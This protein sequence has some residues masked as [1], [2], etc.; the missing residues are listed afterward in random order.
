[1]KDFVARWKGH[2]RI[3]P[4]A[5]PH[6]PYTCSKETLLAARDFALAEGI[7]LLIHVA[8][9][10]QGARR[11]PPRL[12]AEPVRCGS[13]RSASSIPARTAG[14][15]RSSRRTA[16]GWTTQDVAHRSRSTA[17]ALSHNP[18]SNMKLASGIAD[19][20]AWQKAGLAWGLGTDGVAG[21]NNDLSMFEAMDFA[22]KLAKVST[23]DPTVLPA[24]GPRRRGD[25]RRREG[26]RARRRRSAR[27]RPG[28]QADFIAVD[29][30]ERARRAVRRR[31]TRRSSTR[32][33]RRDVT[34]VWVDGRR[35]LGRRGVRRRSTSEAILDEGGRVARKVDAS[36]APAGGRRERT[37]TRE[38]VYEILRAKRDGKEL[39]QGGD[40]V[41]RRRASSRARSPTT[42]R[43]RS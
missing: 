42:R 27:S 14:A 20:V 31:R 25:A 41:P 1:M 6:A 9:T 30:R 4:A 15:S 3:V 36:L 43:R 23:M 5:A 37:S 10:Q 16:S 39:P 22:G 12:A 35:L 18:E 7:P 32:S 24:R 21:S 34:D 28:K 29:V 11:R 2:P 8:E 17:S 19:V 40:R 33:R 13:R 38:I 26:A